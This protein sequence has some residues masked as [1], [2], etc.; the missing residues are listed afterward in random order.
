MQPAV[1]RAARRKPCSPPPNRYIRKPN[2]I[3]RRPSTLPN[4]RAGTP[5]N[6]FTSLKSAK[7]VVTLKRFVSAV[8]VVYLLLAVLFLLVPSVRS[9]IAEMGNGTNQTE[10]FFRVLAWIGVLVLGLQ[11]VVENLDSA[12][13]RRSVSSQDDKINE[14]KARLY[15]HQQKAD[16][17]A[18]TQAATQVPLSAPAP[19]ATSYPE[20]NVPP[21]PLA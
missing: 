8:V 2:G 9:T 7:S 18:A 13:L 4:R 11:L 15:D 21:S 17:R 5:K 20:S 1:G 16:N 19:P 10:D 3:R 6:L 12:L 14:L